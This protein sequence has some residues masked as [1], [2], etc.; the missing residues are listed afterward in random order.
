MPIKFLLLGGVRGFSGREGWKCQFYFYGRGDFSDLKSNQLLEPP[1]PLN[2]QSPGP[3]G[4][5]RRVFAVHCSSGP[6]KATKSAVKPRGRERKRPPEIIQKF[7]LRKWPISSADCPVTPMEEQSTILALFGRRILGQYPAAPFFSWP[8]CFT[9]DWRVHKS[10]GRQNQSFRVC[11]RAPFFPPFLPHSSS[12]F[13]LRALSP[14]LP[15]LPLFTSPL[16]PRKLW[17]R[18]PCPYDKLVLFESP[19]EP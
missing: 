16:T 15:H 1:L 11:F 18:Y 5:P 8:H 6:W 9:A 13:H 7:R 3:W 17:F 12:L 2:L 10:Y 14:L 4:L 19:A